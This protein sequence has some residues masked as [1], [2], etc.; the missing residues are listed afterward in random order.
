[1]VVNSTLR[2][3]ILLI[4]WPEKL[5]E[6]ATD[7]A[8]REEMTTNQQF[9]Q[10]YR[11]TGLPPAE[12]QKWL[13]M[14][15]EQIDKIRGTICS[16]FLSLVSVIMTSLLFIV[17]I[18]VLG[19]SLIRGWVRGLRLFSLG[20]ILWATLGRVGWGIQTFSGRTVPERLNQTWFRFLYCLGV[21]LGALSVWEELL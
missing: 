10:A 17:I 11:T 13:T 19:Y 5:A 21:W 12:R 16:S 15:K 4:L 18:H 14:R 3:L 7:E 1:M 6:L 8:I 9:A 2:D 20:L